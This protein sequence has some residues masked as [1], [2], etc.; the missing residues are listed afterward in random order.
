MNVKRKIVMPTPEEDEVINA[1]I[2]AD[3]DT[4]EADDEWFKKARSAKD[5]FSPEQYAALTAAKRP[6][7][8]PEIEKPKVSTSIRLDADLLEALRATGRG[9]QSRVNSILRE[10]IMRN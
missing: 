9:W 2:A 1:G 4:Y 6:R 8:R 5:F 7:G 10:K 3:P